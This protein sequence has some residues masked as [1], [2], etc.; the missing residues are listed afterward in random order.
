MSER[1]ARV[2]SPVGPLPFS[3]PAAQ[4]IA[5]AAEQSQGKLGF[6]VP[7]SPNPGPSRFGDTLMRLVFQG[8][9]WMTVALLV[10]IFL[11]LLINS[12]RF[13][14]T[15]PFMDFL[16]GKSW[17]P[18]SVVELQ[19]GVMPLLAGTVLVSIATLAI[20]VPFG[21]GLAVYLSRVA[22]KRTREILK[23]I[24]EMIAG[25][26]SVVLGLLGLLYLAPFIA[27]TFHISNG[28]NALNAAILVG[29][30]TV[31]TIASLSEDAITSISESMV[32]ASLALGATHWTS[33][34][35]VVIPA[36]RSGIAGAVMLGLGRAIGETMIVLMV[37]GNSLEFPHSLL[38]P[39]RPMTATIAIEVREV[40]VG[41][42]HW[43]AL[44][45]IGLLLFLI[46]FAINSITDLLLHRSRS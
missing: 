40:V 30:T 33:I 18:V 39:V 29:I 16:F 1:E 5:S 31:P 23:P 37:A 43:S 15:V 25:I 6:L 22:S 8:I 32:E 26:P 41:D 12:Y 24:I 21:L 36:A 38:D 42:L 7:R 20:G 9:A 14:S 4:A 10:G 2:P 19:W 45:A 13:L 28:L 44:F 3:I 17:N 35:R 27:D 46:T 11:F 34:W